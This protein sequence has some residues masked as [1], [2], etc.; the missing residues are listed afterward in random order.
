MTDNTIDDVEQVI[1]GPRYTGK[2][3]WFNNKEGYGF[4]TVCDAGEF[5]AKDIFVHYSSICVEN[6]QYKYL[7]QGEYVEFNLIKVNSDKHD[8]QAVNIS[9]I[10]GGPLMCETKRDLNYVRKPH[11]SSQFINDENY[12]DNDEQIITP[13]TFNSARP[14]KAPR[15]QNRDKKEQKPSRVQQSTVI[16]LNNTLTND[17]FKIVRKKNKTTSQ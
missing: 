16:D 8:S 6:S 15:A 11:V 4:I 12:Q 2:V 3:K 10:K 1:D 14:P 7:V 17:G 5:L 13:K 9:G